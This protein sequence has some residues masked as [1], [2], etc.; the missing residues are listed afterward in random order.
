M[1]RIVTCLLILTSLATGAQST[2]ELRG[3]VY[4]MRSG[5]PVPYATV[6]E[7]K[8]GKCSLANQDGGFRIIL[9][10]GEHSLKFSHIG[11][12]SKWL[13]LTV[14]DTSSPL[15]IYLPPAVIELSDIVVRSRAYDEAQSIIIEA[16]KRK[17]EI[18]QRLNDYTYDAYSRLVVRDESDKDSSEIILIA[19][20]QTTSYWEY[21]DNY[22][23]VLTARKQS[24]NLPAEGNLVVVG[25]VLNFNRN[26]LD[27][28]EWQ[29]VSPTAEDA[30]DYYDYYLTDSTY[31][32]SQKVYTLDIVPKN[33]IDPLLVGKVQIVD[34]T[35]DVVGVDVGFNEAVDLP[36]VSDLRYR[37]KCALFSG[38]YWMPVEIGL[39]ADLQFK[40]PGVPSLMSIDYVASLYSYS[41]EQGHEEV[42]FDE[43]ILEV[44]ESADDL[45]SA[46]WSAHQTIPLTDDE[47]K[48]Y[49]RLDSLAHA[50]KP[51][52]KRLLQGALVATALLTVGD[53]DLFHF[54][55]VDGPYLGLYLS[56]GDLIPRTR[57][58]LSSGYA[59]DSEFWQH[60]YGFRTNLSRKRNL[61]V[62]A[63][64][65]K[66]IVSRDLV[67]KQWYNPTFEALFFKYDPFD[68]YRE[69]GFSLTSAARLVKHT[70][71]SVEYDNFDQN[72][73]GVNTEYSFFGGDD[74]YRHNPV[75]ADGAMRK[76]RAE[77]EYDSRMLFRNKGRDETLGEF[78]YTRITLGGEISSPDFLKSDFDYRKVFASLFRRQRIGGFGAATLNIHAGLSTRTLPPQ[79]YYAIG[80]ADPFAM[81]E[82]GF[83]T[84][85]DSMY[86]GNRVLLLHLRHDFGRLLFQRSGLPLIKDIPFSLSVHGGAFW[87]E[88]KDHRSQVGDELISSAPKPYTEIGFGLGDLTPFIWPFNL[89]V[90]F[91]WQ[92]SDYDTQ[93][94]TWMIGI[95]P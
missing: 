84:I 40:F 80:Y 67:G 60:Q 74:P 30:L 24:A 41:F 44:L 57:L 8:T 7:L 6:Q 53:Y 50:P 65:R 62:G 28:D 51:L 9:E 27:L 76:V 17:R 91:T 73:V 88:F 93:R 81:E 70:N 4:D 31:I 46:A 58:R 90:F 85:N 83:Y 16:I 45:D 48:G 86:Y 29:V 72:S 22:K 11:Y 23:E 32:D 75:I 82:S 36:A 14:S 78:Q 34:S 69:A 43:Y 39:K 42:A 95:S 37:Q 49:Q 63:E 71:L 19:E 38:E 64:Y 25:E 59:F 89:S 61:E 79:S 47:V 77:L 94:F 15:D 35:F 5:Q 10:P 66:K 3:V 18:L 1:S 12:Y 33:Q 26:R 2:M 21:P 52:K 68:Y 54:Q 13:T 92:L 20:T 56:N 87:T 55:R